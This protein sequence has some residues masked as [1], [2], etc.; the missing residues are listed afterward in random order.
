MFGQI[1]SKDRAFRILVLPLLVIKILPIMMHMYSFHLRIRLIDIDNYD[2]DYVM[3]ANL[4]IL[5]PNAA[6]YM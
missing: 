6:W 5:M 4:S 3:L 2:Q 1:A